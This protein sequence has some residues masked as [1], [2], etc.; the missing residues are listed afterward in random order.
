MYHIKNDQRSIRSG[1]LL[2]DGLVKLM[3]EKEFDTITVTDLV[4]VA[5]VG[6]ATFYRNFD[7]IEDVLRLRCDNTVEGLVKNLVDYIPKDT[8]QG[9]APL[10]KPLLRYFAVHSQIIELLIKAKR[11]HIFAEALRSVFEPFKEQ[12]AIRF[13]LNEEYVEYGF[14]V[15]VGAA[16]SLLAHWIQ[17]GKQQDPDELADRLLTMFEVLA[18]HHELI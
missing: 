11:L 5:Q 17:T 18:Q 9:R 4:E 12:S 15:R 10:L 8:T 6:R 1:E 2:F 16:T 14:V 7:E 13:G 3:Q